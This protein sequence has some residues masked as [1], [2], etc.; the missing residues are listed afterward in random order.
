MFQVRIH[1]RGGQGV[2]TAAEML[3]IAAFEEGRHA[4]AFPSFG[5]ER[6]GAP[7][8]AFCRI[9]DQEI[10]LREPIMEPDALII[11]DPTLLYQVDVFAGLKQGGYILINTSRSFDELGLGDYVR[12]WP[13]DKL[14][15]VPATELS[16]KHVGRPMPNVPLLAGFAA[17]SGTIRLES[18]IKAINAKFSDKVAS[19]NIAAASEAYRFVNDE[20]AEARHQETA[21]A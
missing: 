8:V 1:G 21:H 18:V 6:T 20:V 17:A 14:C 4:Q 11:Q 2:V 12:A 3:S 19:N 7:V 15:T 16:R 9:A 5:S 10:R 13:K